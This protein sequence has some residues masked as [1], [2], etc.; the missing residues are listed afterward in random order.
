M[1]IDEFYAEIREK[2]NIFLQDSV[3]ALPFFAAF[4]HPRL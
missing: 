2:V 1:L 3:V 4:P